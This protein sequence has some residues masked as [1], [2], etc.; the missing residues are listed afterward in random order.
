M[1]SGCFA[2]PSKE[3]KQRNSPIQ[4]LNIRK[5][6]ISFSNDYLLQEEEGGVEQRWKNSSGADNTAY[7]G[8]TEENSSYT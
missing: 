5:T 3:D 7:I 6:W 4:G 1:S 8:V 2:K